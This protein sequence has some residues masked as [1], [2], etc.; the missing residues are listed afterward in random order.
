VPNA[1][2]KDRHGCSKGIRDHPAAKSYRYPAKASACFEW[3]RFE[4]DPAKRDSA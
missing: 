2:S 1:N 3:T 4:E